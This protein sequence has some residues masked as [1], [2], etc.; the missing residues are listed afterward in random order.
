MINYFKNIWPFYKLP[1]NG[2][3]EIG[4]KFFDKRCLSVEFN[5]KK[6]YTIGIFISI[7]RDNIPITIGIEYCKPLI[8]NRYMTFVNSYFK[9]SRL[10]GY[11]KDKTY[12][13][14]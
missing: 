13:F 3:K 14:K 1:L 12:Y 7:Y 11:C 9:Q 2:F 5:Y 6:N 8:G 10:G 4:I